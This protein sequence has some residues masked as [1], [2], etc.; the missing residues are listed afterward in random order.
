MMSP[1]QYVQ[2]VASHIQIPE[3]LLV[4][5]DQDQWFIWFGDGRDIEEIPGELA[6]W[7]FHRP[8]MQALASPRMWFDDSSLP[9]RSGSVIPDR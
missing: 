7:I 9:V 6:S 3:R 5:N 4:R 1:K 8:E 2:P